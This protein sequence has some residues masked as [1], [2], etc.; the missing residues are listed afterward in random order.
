MTSKPDT[1]RRL[2]RCVWFALLLC[3][4]PI[5]AQE[6]EPDTP[7]PPREGEAAPEF[8]PAPD[9]VLENLQALYDT[10]GE[11]TPPAAQTRSTSATAQFLWTLAVLLGII[12]AILLL[13]YLAKRFGARTPALA[14]LRL[15]NVLGRIYLT[16]K[17]SLHYVKTGGRVLVVGVTP[18]GIHLLTEFTADAFEAQLADAAAPE[19]AATGEEIGPNF[20]EYLNA[21]Q[22]PN[23]ATADDDLANLRGEIQRLSEFLRESSREP[24]G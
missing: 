2:A 18:T 23:R 24:Q 12:G 11:P 7:P 17:A 21:A 10:P 8:A 1:L 4:A 16:P 3:A 19:S 14:G 5:L 22:K 6:P 13:G 20:L 15:G 9:P